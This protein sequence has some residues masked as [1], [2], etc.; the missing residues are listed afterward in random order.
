M[1]ASNPAVP[2]AQASHYHGVPTTI[3][4]TTV[5]GHVLFD[6][7][8]PLHMGDP[9]AEHYVPEWESSHPTTVM[10]GPACV[11]CDGRPVAATF[12]SNVTCGQ[13]TLSPVN[14]TIIKP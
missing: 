6:R 8:P 7:M 5:A 13:I 14:S 10:S 11:L 2:G 3:T 1:S 4:G 12:L 9:W